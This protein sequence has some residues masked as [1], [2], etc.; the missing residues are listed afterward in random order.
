MNSSEPIEISSYRKRI[1]GKTLILTGILGSIFALI[2]MWDWTLG[3]ILGLSI[4]MINFV[5]LCRHT[6]RLADSP[7]NK[8]KGIMIL[9]HWMRYLL[10]GTV[11]YLVYKKNSVSFPGFLIGMALVYAVIFIDGFWKMKSDK[12][13]QS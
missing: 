3:I 12:A 9:G 10:I 1:T 7:A 2:G 11:V 5:L 6:A 8:A 13:A 4:G